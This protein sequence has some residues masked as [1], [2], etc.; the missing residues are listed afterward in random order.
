VRGASAVFRRELGAYLGSPV[1]WVVCILF[2]LVLH[3]LWFFLGYPIGDLRLPAFW[4]GRIASLDT[5]YAW[6]PPLFGILAPALT[7][8]SWAEERRSGTDELLLAQPVRL[9]EIV[10]GKFAASWLLIAS[11]CTIAVLPA[12]GM[13]ALVGPLDR[14]TVVG[15]LLGAWML[16]A[17]CVAVGQLASALSSEDLVAFLLSAVVLLGLWSAG[18]FV[19]VLPAPAAE[20]AWYVSPSLHFLE[21]GARG[22]LDARDL[23]YHGLFAAGALLATTAILEGRRWR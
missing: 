5:L 21:S 19:R 17:V 6:L 16:A 8:G 10:L 11:V 4:A 3:G 13:V 20:V 12:A 9:R 7:M 2:V 22:L 15:G 14:G 23:V 1:A 18:L